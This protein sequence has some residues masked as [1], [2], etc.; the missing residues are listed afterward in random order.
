M[1][2]EFLYICQCQNYYKIGITRD[3]KG[4]LSAMRTNNP[5]PIRLFAAFNL[6]PRSGSVQ[7]LSFTRAEK[8]LHE[9]FSD[10]KVRGE[11]FELTT[12][13]LVDTVTYLAILCN[14]E[15]KRMG[16]NVGDLMQAKHEM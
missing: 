1:R 7:T 10:K 11:W 14:D 12:E 4:R 16:G 8:Y 15:E 13:D 9:N 2:E 6:T 5:F 3:V